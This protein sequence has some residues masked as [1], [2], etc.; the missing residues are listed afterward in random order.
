MDDESG[1]MQ[2]FDCLSGKFV[3]EQSDYTVKS[4]K[5]E[6]TIGTGRWVDDEH[7]VFLKLIIQHGANWKKV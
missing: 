7:F 3:S 5:K 2:L 6:L 4:I 1:V